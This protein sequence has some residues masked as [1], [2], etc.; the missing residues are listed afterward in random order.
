MNLMNVFPKPFFGKDVCPGSDQNMN[1]MSDSIAFIYLGAYSFIHLACTQP[2]HSRKL[3]A[4]G[5]EECFQT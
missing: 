4:G 3:R 5:C 2:Y 1:Y